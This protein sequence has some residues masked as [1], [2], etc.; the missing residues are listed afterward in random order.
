MGERVAAVGADRVPVLAKIDGPAAE[1]GRREGVTELVA[2]FPKTATAAMLGR[3]FAGNGG[4][5]PMSPIL[6]PSGGTP[7]SM[8]MTAAPC[9]YPPSTIRVAGHCWAMVEMRLVASVAPSAAARKS[10]EAG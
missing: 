3:S 2:G 10:Y 1:N 7:A 4:A 6:L 5:D 8:S 9:E